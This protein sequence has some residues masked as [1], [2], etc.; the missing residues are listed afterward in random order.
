MVIEQTLYIGT[1]DGVF[2]LDISNIQ[3]Y[4]NTQ[5]ALPK[6]DLIIPHIAVW[7]FYLHNDLLLVGANEGLYEFN[8]DTQKS[9]FLLSFDLY[10]LSIANNYVRTLTVDKNGLYWMGSASDG[11]FLWDPKSNSIQNY[12]YKKG[13]E[14][15]LSNN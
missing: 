10:D 14:S 3:Q 4:Y 12:G 1:N 2:T 6:F 7:Q 13:S 9:H 15:S 8:V 5:S 11:L